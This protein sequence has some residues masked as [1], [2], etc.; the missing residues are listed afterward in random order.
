MEYISS[1]NLDMRIG[2]LD[3]S[4]IAISDLG[5]FKSLSLIGLINGNFENHPYS[6]K[7]IGR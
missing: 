7:K 6:W 4:L 1:G 2:K 3:Y 5:S